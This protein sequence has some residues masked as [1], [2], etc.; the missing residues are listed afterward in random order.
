MR[1]W[2][3]KL[4]SRII[5]W[6]A[7]LRHPRREWKPIIKAAD[8]HLEEVKKKAS[9]SESYHDSI[10]SFVEKAKKDANEERLEE[11]N[12]GEA[13][14]RKELGIPKDIAPTGLMRAK[15]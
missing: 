6:L 9:E 5:D 10:E 12:N 8:D 2:F 11:L 15:D 13:E 14:L 4:L 7:E 3:D 1:K